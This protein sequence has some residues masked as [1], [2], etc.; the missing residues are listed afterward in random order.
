MSKLH[1]THELKC[2]PDFFG[3][4]VSGAKTFDLRKNDRNFKVGDKLVLRE[5]D[6]RTGKY[7]GEEI[8]RRITYVL[9][10]IGGGCIPPLQGL[11][12]GFCIL[13]IGPER[14]DDGHP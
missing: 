3:P 9:D 8:R 13:G 12:R 11:Q 2:W 14:E 4:I 7:T 1:K 5:F 10:G 6:D